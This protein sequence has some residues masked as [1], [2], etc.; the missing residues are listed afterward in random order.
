MIIHH[1]SWENFQNIASGL[2]YHN[3]EDL[4][5]VE[6]QNSAFGFLI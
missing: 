6:H 5:T 2:W 1:I 3:I 4:K